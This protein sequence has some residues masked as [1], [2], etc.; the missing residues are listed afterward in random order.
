[1]A[2]CEDGQMHRKSDRGYRRGS[3]LATRKNGFSVKGVKISIAKKGSAFVYG[4]E[5]RFKE[6]LYLTGELTNV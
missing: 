6:Y 2:V 4:A 5:R 3:E 1:M